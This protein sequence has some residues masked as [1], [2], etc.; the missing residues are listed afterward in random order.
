MNPSAAE[1]PGSPMAGM[2][3]LEVWKAR[4]VVGLQGVDDNRL[5]GRAEPLSSRT[6]A[7]CSSVTPRTA[8]VEDIINAL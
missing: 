8:C 7:R 4:N 6:T 5:R 2:P 1:D 3:V